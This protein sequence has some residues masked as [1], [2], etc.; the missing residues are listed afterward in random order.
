MMKAERCSICG[1]K[2]FKRVAQHKALAHAS[3]RRKKEIS[4]NI[5]EGWNRRSEYMIK[6]GYKR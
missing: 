6:H 4:N 3:K 1:K 5:K 2:G